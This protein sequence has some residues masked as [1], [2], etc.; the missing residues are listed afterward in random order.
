M[1][2]AE[3]QILLITGASKSFMFKSQYLW[4]KFLHP[5]PKFIS[6]IQRIQVGNGQFVSV[7]FIIPVVI[8]IHGPGFE[9]FTLVSDIHE[10][11][12]LVFGIK[13]IF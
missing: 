11:L 4:C 6:K 5:L 2:E 13:N 9:I 8:D 3:C 10:N 1:D 12:D 7:F